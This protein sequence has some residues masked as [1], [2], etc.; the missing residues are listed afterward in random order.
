L[1]FND[2]DY[3]VNTQEQID[4]KPEQ[5]NSL[6]KQIKLTSWRRVGTFFYVMFAFLFN[7]GFDSYL[8]NSMSPP[9]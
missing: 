2:S 9:L 4:K 5:G 1:K 8:A 7:E 6:G 3:T